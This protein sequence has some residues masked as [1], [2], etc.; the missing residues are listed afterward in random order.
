MAKKTAKKKTSKKSTPET[1][2]ANLPVVL[3]K[4]LPPAP[5]QTQVT[6]NDEHM[7]RSGMAVARRTYKEQ[8]E[9]STA[10]EERLQKEIHEL[11]S[12]AQEELGVCAQA[13]VE[14]LPA[15]TVCDALK[16]LGFKYVGIN[17]SCDLPTKIKN[18]YGK[19][20]LNVLFYETDG[21]GKLS[22]T[23]ILSRP[24]LSA[25]PATVTKILRARDKK[26]EELCMQQKVT[27][28]WSD[29]LDSIEDKRDEYY[30]ALASKIAT[31]DPEVQATLEHVTGT[32]QETIVK[33]AEKVFEKIR[34]TAG[35]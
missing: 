6:L 34:A 30:L 7:I 27:S 25:T 19:Y 14:G 12:Q 32:I 8:L 1:Q 4:P 17:V 21:K 31:L 9:A 18:R 24:F 15:E 28:H 5:L 11:V 3:E 22:G 26:A 29:E 20:Q 2:A 23:N 35:K 16:L 13:F 33:D 10:I